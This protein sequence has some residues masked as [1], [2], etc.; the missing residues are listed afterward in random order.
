MDRFESEIIRSSLTFCS[1][2]MG[3][4]LRN[5]AYSSNIKDRMD[6]SCAVLDPDGRLLAQAEHIPVHLGSLP[7]GLKRT[8]EY[9]E[10]EGIELMKGDMLMVNNP[11]LSGTHLNDITLIC[12]IVN[13]GR[14]VAYSCNKAHHSDVGGKVPGSI[15]SDATDI[16]QEGIILDPVKLVRKGAVDREV[17]SMLSSNSRDPY[18]RK[19]DV[20]AQVAANLLGEKR[21]ISLIRQYGLKSFENA[22]GAALDYSERM[23]RKAIASF[24]DRTGNAADCMEMPSGDVGMKV[25]VR[26]NE[27]SI[28]IDYTGTAGQVKAPVNAVYG[29]T[30]SAVYYVL[31]C[32]TDPDIMMNDGCFR[33]VAVHVPEGTLLNPTFPYPVSAGNTE[34]SQRNADLLFR[35]FYGIVPE[36]ISASCGGSMNNI[37]IGGLAGGRTWSFYETNAVGMGASSGKDGID[38]IHCNMT[39]TLNTP[40]EL[41]ELYYPLSITRY[42]FRDGSG[43]MGEWRGGAGIERSFR[44]GND[45]TLLTVMAERERHAPQGLNGGLEGARTE[46]QL[47][48]GG[49]RERIPSKCTVE[50]SEGDIVTIFTAGGGGFGNPSKREK[51][52][53]EAD[54]RSGLARTDSSQENAQ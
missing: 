49:R 21:I 53:A 51:A 41:V 44:I 28:S 47:E 11:Y 24:P 20:R 23:V 50:L 38:G 6:H 18:Q 32:I 7:W 16:F 2:E 33:P 19:G 54:R 4:A 9:T 45:Q 5:S 17:L 46:I 43:G 29:V 3:I 31:K 40:A 34:T 15:P 27:D 26:K 25:A 30:L 10:R 36:R 13:G 22:A 35:A 52:A 12:P 14:T 37:M 39:N 42:Q 8:L 48:R 1:E